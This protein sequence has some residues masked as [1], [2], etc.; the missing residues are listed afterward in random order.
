MQ[1]IKVG[2]YVEIDNDHL[3]CQICGDKLNVDDSWS[4]VCPK[5][6]SYYLDSEGNWIRDEDNK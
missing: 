1:E 3:S 2:D 5:G 6:H 4:Y